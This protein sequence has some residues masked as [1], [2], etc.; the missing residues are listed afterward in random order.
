M[1]ELPII[2]RCIKCNN[3]TY[4]LNGYCLKCFGYSDDDIQQYIEKINKENAKA[5]RKL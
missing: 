4:H 2:D 3:L 1:K 5:N